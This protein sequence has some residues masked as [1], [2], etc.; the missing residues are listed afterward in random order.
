M[1]RARRLASVA[2]LLVFAPVFA[3]CDQFGPGG[4]IGK[5]LCPE[6]SGGDPLSAQYSVNARANA[7]IRAFVQASKDMAAVSL[8]IEGEVADACRR[9]GADLG[10]S[11]QE[12]QP[13]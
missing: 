7:K 13:R 1:N 6:L 8:Q 4:G 3:S 9:M 5:A 10:I 11:P 12:M 2:F